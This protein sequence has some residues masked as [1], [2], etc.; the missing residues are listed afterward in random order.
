MRTFLIDMSDFRNTES[1]YP[2]VDLL[3]LGGRY[4]PCYV[5]LADWLAGAV[6]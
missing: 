5:E 2:H 3:D 1:G 4:V 6:Q